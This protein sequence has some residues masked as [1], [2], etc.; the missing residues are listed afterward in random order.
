[1]DEFLDLSKQSALEQRQREEEDVLYRLFLKERKT[2]EPEVM[3]MDDEERQVLFEDLNR[4][5]R[6]RMINLVDKHCNQMMDLIH[7]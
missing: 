4:K 2:Q 6:S 5:E 7:R 1:M 3:L